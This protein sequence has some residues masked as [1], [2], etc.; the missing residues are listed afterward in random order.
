[1]AEG[2]R[3]AKAFVE[4]GT[5][6]NTGTGLNAIGGKIKGWVAGLGIGVL[7]ASAISPGIAAFGTFEKQ[8]NEVFSL[9][10]GISQ[11]AMDDMSG[12][13][14]KFAKD[15]GVL[16]D[17]VV[18]SLYEALSSGV[19]KDN[20]FEFLEIAQKA[21]K[22]GV[23][24][25]ATAVDGITSVINAYGADVIDATQAS[26]MM[27]EAVKG[28][29]MTFGELSGELSKVTPLASALQLGF[30]NVTAAM[31]SMTAVG[32]PAAESATYLRSLLA[33]LSQAG[34]ETAETFET[35]AGK[36]FKEFIAGGG[37]LQDAL[38]LMETHA[39][40][41]GVGVND[42]FGSIEA[43]S[44]ALA[45]TGKGTEMFKQ[46]LENAANSAGSTQAA[47]DQ[48][49]QGIV[50][51]WDKAKAAASVALI[52]LGDKLAPAVLALGNFASVTIPK[53]SAA[54]DIVGGMMR[55]KV[56]PF[57]QSNVFP[58]A[59]A[60][61]STIAGVITTLV[62]PALQNEVFPKVIEI[63]WNI[64]GVVR[65]NV[66][67]ALADVG[68]FVMTYIVPALQHGAWPAFIVIVQTVWAV[69]SFLGNILLNN[70]IPAVAAVV[71]WM[72]RNAD[73]IGIVAAVI[74]TI[75]L[76]ALI[77]LGIK[78][79]ATLA[80]MIA[81]WLLWQTMTVGAMVI[82]IGQI[83]VMVAKWIWMGFVSTAQAAKVVAGW[84]VMAAKAIASAAVQVAQ[85]ALM[86][87]KWMWMGIQATLA[88]A[89]VVAAY[90]AMK[91]Q[92][93]LSAGIQ[94]AQMVLMGIRWVALGVIALA[95]G[96]QIALAWLLS[97]GPIGLVIAAVIAIAALIIIFWDEIKAAFFAAIEWLKTFLSAAWDGIVAGVSAAW[98][99][100]KNFFIEYWPII[101]GI[102]TG[103][104]GLIIGLIIQNWDSIKAK[105][106]EIWNA[107]KNFFSNWWNGLK[108]TFTAVLIAIALF[109][110]EKQNAIKA[111][112]SEI[113][114][115]IKA[116]FTNWW[117]AQKAA[118]QAA[119]QKVKD[120]FNNW[121][122]IIQKVKD[123]FNSV[124][125]AAT[126]KLQAMIDW[127]KGLPNK[128][129]DAIGNIKSK[130][131]QKG[132]D[133]VQGIWDGIKQ[134][135]GWLADKISGWAADAIPGPIADA[136]GIAS[137]SRV[138]AAKVGR[139]IPAG[140]S[141]GV[142]QGTPRMIAGLRRMANK[143]PQSVTVDRGPTRTP[144]YLKGEGGTQNHFAP[145]SVVLDASKIK[146]V[147]DLIEMINSVR[148]TSRQYGSTSGSATTSV[149]L[150]V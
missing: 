102:F 127:V 125:S 106:S 90:V 53:V 81:R 67:P 91:V 122:A 21:A 66:L 124:K 80:M 144:E 20:V 13:V 78:S 16:P 130:L 40:D 109:M 103:G 97:L 85:F 61:F 147:R 56:I 55:D 41:T 65:D 47:Y 8:M 48:M 10:P 3:I 116:F 2:F 83:A 70:V 99:W 108:A 128:I 150:G 17:Q 62:I 146:D 45:L 42:L 100:I 39:K 114:N 89:K 131:I 34:G 145:G 72:A 26:D 64:V 19:P 49:N 31:A 6:D 113:W 1:M 137:P 143:I 133:V 37:N 111:K 95:A 112:I 76:P 30:G 86:V 105:A 29:K 9:L 23:T 60:M 44:A 93:L 12:Q 5:E 11:S 4:V 36:S 22:G 110:L 107:I 58:I 43:G 120:Y 84:A 25:L 28:G 119:I 79:A 136:L 82:H 73:V 92:A 115:A 7:M 75:M 68:N 121:S 123:T 142:D 33:E 57:F 118:F 126:D 74:T 59:S 27:F 71:G 51:A 101:L 135:G 35:V 148:S 141:K 117:N 63:F 14:K 52:D 38:V 32:I 69:L 96:A 50:N 94:I 88:V 87:A 140:I 24:E 18:P 138:M 139:W 149:R 132:K 134:M 104:L 98:E 46:Q 77:A 15:F 129:K 54:L